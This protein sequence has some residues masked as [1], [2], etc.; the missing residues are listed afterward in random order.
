MRLY[1]QEIIER[2]RFPRHRGRIE[3]PHAQAEVANTFCGDEIALFM[4]FDNDGKVAEAKF[5]GE[6]CALMTA[7]ADILCGEIEGKTVEE[8]HRFGVEDLL[9]LYGERP[10]PGR[11]RC[12]LLPHEALTRALQAVFPIRDAVVK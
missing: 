7:S 4:N 9:A 11:L 10:T 6:G 12:V 3:R 8:L 1:R 2:W 5:E